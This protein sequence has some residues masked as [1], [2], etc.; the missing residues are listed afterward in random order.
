MK[1]IHRVEN[2]NSN[3]GTIKEIVE[4]EGKKFKLEAALT[5]GSNKLNAEIMDSDGVFKFVLGSLDVDFRYEASYVSDASSICV[6]TTF[7]ICTSSCHNYLFKNY[8]SF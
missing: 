1:T 8:F 6:F 7:L 5:N 2:I 3:A 4:F